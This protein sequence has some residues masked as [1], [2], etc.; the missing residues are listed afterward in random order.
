MNEKEQDYCV[1]VLLG[2]GV[3]GC[4]N[5]WEN[6]EKD[7]VE[8]GTLTQEDISVLIDARKWHTT[9]MDS[10]NKYAIFGCTKKY[11]DA[12]FSRGDFENW[13]VGENDVVCIRT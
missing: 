9:D 8:N 5:S 4:G 10:D 13:E 2:G 6:A 12:Y 11:H 7:A 1:I 3:Y